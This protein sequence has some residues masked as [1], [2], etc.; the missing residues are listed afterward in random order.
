MLLCKY[1]Y[2]ESNSIFYNV[3]VL[4]KDWLSVWLIQVLNT[5]ITYFSIF[6]KLNYK[7]AHAVVADLILVCY[8]R[9]SVLRRFNKSSV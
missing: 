1:D 8:E 3:G 9:N 4:Y 2:M 7:S 5:S 6:L